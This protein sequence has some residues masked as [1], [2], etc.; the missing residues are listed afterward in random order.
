MTVH[1]ALSYREAVQEALAGGSR[2]A[3]LY[4]SEG[5]AVVRAALV[6][7]D[8][9]VAIESVAARAGV[10]PTIV[11]LAAGRRLGRARGTRPL[12]RPLR[13]PRAVAA[14]RR[15]R[16]A[17]RPLDGARTRQGRLSGRGRPDP[18]RGHRVRP[19][20]LPRR[21]RQDPP[22]RRAPLL[23]AP[24]PRARRRGEHPR[25]RG[26]LRRPRLRSLRGRERPC[27]RPRMR[28][29]PR[30]RADTGARPRTDDP[31]RARASLEPPQRHRRRLRR[32]RPRRGQQPLR[33]AHRTRAPTERGPDRAPLPVRH[34]RA[35][36]QLARA[37]RR[38]RATT[39]ARSSTRFAP[40]PSVAGASSSSTPR[41]RIGSRTSGSSDPTTSNGSAP[42][43]RR[44]AQPV[45][46][47]TYASTVFAWSTR[48]SSHAPPTGR[49]GTSAPG[50][51]SASSSCARRSIS[52]TGSSTGP[53]GRPAR[54]RPGRRRRAPKGSS[55][56]R[57]VRR[58]ASSSATATD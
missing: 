52:S 57:G 15:A 48:T 54:R 51:T 45:S 17:A 38:H 40:R 16:S 56:P 42:S 32:C 23:Q 46:P 34:D 35:R 29:G 13:R 30:A 39:P 6:A 5:G 21:R 1:A 53:S 26:P 41:S 22:P 28:G 3:G 10:V 24:R 27:L 55:N 49:T 4:A 19:L 12:R 37:G 18:C 31:A 8:G 43:G 14:T 2:F 44:H 20:P 36:R 58:S 9:A 7:P 11:D 50:S 25:G 33:G 47:S